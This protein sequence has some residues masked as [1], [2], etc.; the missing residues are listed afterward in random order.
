MIFD[1]ARK[2]YILII[3]LILFTMISC[4]GDKN[5]SISDNG[6]STNK[7]KTIYDYDENKQIKYKVNLIKDKLSDSKNLEPKKQILLN[8]ERARL[9]R[10]LKKY[11]KANELL[12]K[13]MKLLNSFDNLKDYQK[14]TPICIPNEYE[15]LS[16]ISILK[17]KNQDKF[18]KIAEINFENCYYND[19]KGDIR[20]FIYHEQLLINITKNNHK[21]CD[22]LFKKMYSLLEK[23]DENFKLWFMIEDYIKYKYE[24]DD[25]SFVSI[26]EQFPIIKDNYYF[27]YLLYK[28]HIL[29]NDTSNANQYLKNC[30]KLKYAY[31]NNKLGHFV[32][33]VENIYRI[34]N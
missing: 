31:P 10:L 26:F 1:L 15:Y 14:I 16:E 11:D 27:N 13:Q 25:I 22:E 29:I 12:E 19:L 34:G 7:K 30:K 2:Y 28:K 21:L 20:L 4:N 18:K 6:N 9:Y 24:Q 32:E 8:I 17:N 3:I 33:V 5:N 23:N